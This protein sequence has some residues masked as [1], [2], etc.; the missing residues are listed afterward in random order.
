MPLIQVGIWPRPSRGVFVVHLIHRIRTGAMAFDEI[1]PDLLGLLQEF[2]IYGKGPC[3]LFQSR[4]NIVLD[5]VSTTELTFGTIMTGIPIMAD[6]A[7]KDMF[8]A[9]CF[10]IGADQILSEHRN[11]VLLTTGT[12]DIFQQQERSFCG[13][14]EMVLR[15]FSLIRFIGF[16]IP[17]PWSFLL[18]PEDRNM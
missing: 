8:Q 16:V 15:K 1:P 2:E 5:D 6:G 14:C 7:T 9:G 13:T 3:D 18:M 10:P 4:H 17:I 11:N 12:D